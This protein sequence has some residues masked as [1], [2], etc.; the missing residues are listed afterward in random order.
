MPSEFPRRPRTG[1]PI[2]ENSSSRQF[3]NR[4]KEELVTYQP[5]PP[6][7]QYSEQPVIIKLA[8]FY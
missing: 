8:L 1:S 7:P 6:F 2:A 5:L 4:G 3:M